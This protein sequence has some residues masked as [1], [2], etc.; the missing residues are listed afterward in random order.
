MKSFKKTLSILLALSASPSFS[1][2]VIDRIAAVVG[3][4][5]IL[6]S[7]VSELE[8]KLKKNS[9]LAG[10]YN[11]QSST[12]TFDAVLQKMIEEKVVHF[13]LKEMD[14]SVADSE[15]DSRLAGIAKKNNLTLA[16]LETSVQG[17]G[18]PFDFYKKNIRA[19][20]ERQT[21]FERELRK[22]GGIGENELKELYAKRAKTEVSLEMISSEAAKDL[23][24]IKETI[25]SK[26]MSLADIES[27]FPAEDFGWVTPDSLDNKI[28]KMI[29]NAKVGDV[30]GPVKVGGK[31]CLLIL[32]AR[33]KGS[34][35]DF[36]K[37]K[38]E[39][40]QEAQSADYEKRFGS[41]LDRK[42]SEIHIVVNK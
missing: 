27:S 40:M 9:S 30:L 22:G 34:D 21:V 35:E 33:R 39:L 11:L 41:W 20:L 36:Q 2:T 31:S 4:E 16:Q 15:V 38:G 24:K 25:V 6:Q 26:K 28:E 13:A 42:K 7:E 18:I 14:A 19:Q 23:P 12:V 8:T 3:D 17:E 32:K 10:L 37:V 29:D 1:K 5:P